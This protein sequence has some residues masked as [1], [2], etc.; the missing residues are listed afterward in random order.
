M[1]RRY[2]THELLVKRPQV[3]VLMAV[4]RAELREDRPEPHREAA[5]MADFA[6]PD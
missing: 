1:T 6:L 2:T 5:K 3:A 4:R